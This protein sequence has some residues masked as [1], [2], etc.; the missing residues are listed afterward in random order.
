MA[1]VVRRFFSSS[2]ALAR[3]RVATPAPTS[4]M[5]LLETAELQ[6][7][8]QK[9]TGSWK[10]LSKEEVVQRKRSFDCLGNFVYHF[11]LPMVCI[12]INAH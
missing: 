9:A 4:Q 8:A 12:L 2:S 3:A 5:T 10:Q 7:L 6:Q 11:L 1:F